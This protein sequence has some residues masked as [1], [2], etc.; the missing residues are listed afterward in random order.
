[1]RDEQKVPGSLW[2]QARF[3]EFIFQHSH[4]GMQVG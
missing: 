2:G 3:C 1:M 4:K